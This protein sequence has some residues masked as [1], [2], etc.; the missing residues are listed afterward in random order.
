MKSRL[1]HTLLKWIL[2]ITSRLPFWLLY[3]IS[4][5]IFLIVYFII[6]YRREIVLKNISDSFPELNE[7]DHNKL[8]RRFYRHFSDYIVETIKINH[9][10]DKQMMRHMTFENIELV[11][12]LL[13]KGRSV[14]AYF[15][16][17]G[18]WEWATSVTLWSQ[19]GIDG[20]AKYCQVYRPLKDQWFDKYFLHL[21]SRFNSLSIKKRSVLRE[22]IKFKR[23]N[24]LTVTGFM[25]DQKPSGGDDTHILMFLNHP[26]AV[27]TG[28]ETLARKLDMSVIYFDMEKVKRGHYH[29]TLRLIA[30][31]C[32]TMPQMSITDTYIRLL[33]EN[34]RR[35]PAIWLWTHNRWKH[36]VTLPSI[37]TP[38][39]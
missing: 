32:A 31:D 38:A 1:Y 35:N 27:I 13:S 15:S 5:I 18:N 20:T 28:T 24:T 23:S 19:F 2:A 8:I 25:S 29:I 3:R 10:S 4:D 36:K 22:L 9:I 26:T 21:R 30:E 34:I 11:D 33:E 37:Q 16:H 7:A 14:V 39:V 6:R 17:C 12:E